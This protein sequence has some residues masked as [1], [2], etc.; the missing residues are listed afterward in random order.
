MR[1][2]AYS[3]KE[4]GGK[5]EPFFYERKI[6]SREVLVKI[7]HCGIATGDIQGINNDWGDTKFPL[8][9]GHEIIGVIEKVGSAVKDLKI[10]NR[11]GVGYQQEAC[12][13]CP[14][15]KEGN[16][17]FCARQKVIAV[18]C[19]GGLAEHIIVDERFAFKLPRKID[20]AKSI[21]L[22]SSGLT[23]YS[24]IVRAKLKKNSAVAVA[25]IGGLGQLAIRFLHKMGHSVSAFSHS[26]EK[27]DM[28]I[29]LGATYIDSSNLNN[30]TDHDKE[31]DFILSTLN[32]EFNLDLYLKMLKPQGKLGLVAQPL[33]KLSLNAGLLYDYAQRTIF[34]SYT[35]SRKNMKIM[36]AFS[37]KNAI[38]SKVDVLPFAEMNKAI[39]IVK[40]GKTLK[41]IVL[42]NQ[43]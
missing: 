2:E 6:S 36:L 3:I 34:G 7:T 14:F 24:A 16:E 21:P 22:L 20:A 37:A 1:I 17:Q 27:K 25:G 33:N 31:F 23:V 30:L 9:P 39:E 43:K 38:E 19:Y 35:G 5:A 32:V 11:V 12:F 40:A 15:C 41:R 42:E 26:P 4:Q 10:G 8:V 29:Q 18:D 13:E 28:I